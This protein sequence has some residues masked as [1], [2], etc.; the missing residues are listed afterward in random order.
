VRLFELM[1]KKVVNIV[2]A[3]F[4]ADPLPLEPV[5]KERLKS[6]HVDVSSSPMSNAIEQFQLR[7]R[8]NTLG[9]VLSPTSGTFVRE[10]R[11]NRIL[12]HF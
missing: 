5:K 7:V 6:M 9:T 1:E 3:P 10:K 12:F 8:S 11:V 4:S 2:Y